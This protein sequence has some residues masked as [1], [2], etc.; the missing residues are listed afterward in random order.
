MAAVAG[1][2]RDQKILILNAEC[3]RSAHRFAT[4]NLT[5]A[6]ESLTGPN[7]FDAEKSE[8]KA[9]MKAVTS[10]IKKLEQAF[11][12]NGILFRDPHDASL[13]KAVEGFPVRAHSYFHNYKNQQKKTFLHQPF[14]L[15]CSHY[16]LQSQNGCLGAMLDQ[17]SN[18]GEELAPTCVIAEMDTRDF[19]I[20]VAVI[21]PS[22]LHRFFEVVIPYRRSGGDSTRG[23]VAKV[24]EHLAKRYSLWRVFNSTSQ[25]GP[26][27]EVGE[28][29]LCVE[30]CKG[31]I[32]ERAER[33]HDLEHAIEAIA[34]SVNAKGPETTKVLPHFQITPITPAGVRE[35]LVG[36]RIMQTGAWYDVFISYGKQDGAKKAKDVKDCLEQQGLTTH[37]DGAELGPGEDW[38]R[39]LVEGVQISS[40]VAVVC[41][42]KSLHRPWIA[43][44][45][46]CALGLGKKVTPILCGKVDNDDIP[47]YLRR[48]QWVVRGQDK[49]LRDYS[50]KVLQ[51]VASLRRF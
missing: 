24:T 8:H 33:R 3:S 30:D 34:L 20:R 19:N 35:R 44:E 12:G 26:D 27:V 5:L 28:V 41:T 51:R 46:G 42:A 23:L 32:L 22:E 11:P 39:K 2:L 13:K 21:P 15:Y 50:N 47:D 1:W 17:L 9:T 14:E 6:F 7:Q 31:G 38:H 36:E 25:N 45:I 29:S 43:M 4:W 48:F 18:K 37:L 40:E 10:L 16:K 49:K